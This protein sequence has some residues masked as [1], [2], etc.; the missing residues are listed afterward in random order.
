MVVRIFGDVTDAQDCGGQAALMHMSELGD[1]D[2]CPLKHT[3]Q[4]P[5]SAYQMQEAR[6]RWSRR[7]SRQ[8][9]PFLECRDCEL[10]FFLLK[11]SILPTPSL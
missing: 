2:M 11:Q 3:K 5:S 1:I 8:P 4:P 10:L 9:P 6:D 7:G